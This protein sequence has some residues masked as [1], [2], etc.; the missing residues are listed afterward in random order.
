MTN[1]VEMPP[2]TFISAPGANTA[3][4]KPSCVQVKNGFPTRRLAQRHIHIPYREDAD[5][6]ILVVP[7]AGGQV[8]RPCRG[9]PQGH[10]VAVRHREFHLRHAIVHQPVAGGRQGVGIRQ[11]V[12]PEVP[13]AQVVRRLVLHIGFPSVRPGRIPRAAVYHYQ[14]DRQP[15]VDAANT[16]VKMTQMYCSIAIPPSCAI[17]CRQPCGRATVSKIC[18]VCPG[19]FGPILLSQEDG[20]DVCRKSRDLRC[21]HRAASRFEREN[22]RPRCWRPPMRG[23]PTHGSR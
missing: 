15:A 3:K 23:T 1:S 12:Q 16:A 2:I 14:H 9:G 20:E 4:S 11:A 19:A 10:V 21:K 8:Q 7:V 5:A 18:I 17:L 6:L 13:V 22:K